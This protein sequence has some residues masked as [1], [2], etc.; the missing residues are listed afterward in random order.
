L[1]R[2]S[3]ARR[4]PS[5][6]RMR[7]ASSRPALSRPRT[8]EARP[9]LPSPHIPSSRTE[10]T[11]RNHHSRSHLVFPPP[12]FSLQ[13][14]VVRL[15][16]KAAAAN[17]RLEHRELR[18]PSPRR[19]RSPTLR[20]SKSPHRSP[21]RSRAAAA[22]PTSPVDQMI[23]RAYAAPAP[24][25]SPTRLR[26]ERNRER[27]AAGSSNGASEEREKRESG[28]ERVMLSP[29]RRIAVD[30]TRKTRQVR[31]HPWCWRGLFLLLFACFFITLALRLLH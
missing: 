12:S 1:E 27:G 4:R 20:R 18:D 2:C 22:S 16:K 17:T 9:L 10:T 24:S 7:P 14:L 8:I 19:R 15:R 30:R 25:P 3:R 23:Q 29:I 13:V 31:D 6:W 26:L 28:R 11:L 5:S 21:E